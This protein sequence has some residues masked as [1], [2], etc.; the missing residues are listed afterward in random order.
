[1]RSTELGPNQFQVLVIF[2]DDSEHIRIG[3]Q[4]FFERNTFFGRGFIPQSIRKI[5]LVADQKISFCNYSTVDPVG[6]LLV[7]FDFGT[8]VQVETPEGS[9]LPGFFHEF[10]SEFRG[11]RRE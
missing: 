5:T 9:L 2:G 7:G 8:I 11:F 6:F 3:V 10:H 1:M 4:P